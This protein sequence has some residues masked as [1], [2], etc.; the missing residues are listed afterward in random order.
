QDWID[1][2]PGDPR[3][4][5]LIVE[6]VKQKNLIK[7]LKQEDLKKL[8]KKQRR[9]LEERVWKFM[10]AFRRILMAHAMERPYETSDVA[11]IH[12]A[13]NT[14]LTTTLVKMDEFE[15]KKIHYLEPQFSES[16]RSVAELLVKYL[17]LF[18]L[19][20]K[21]V[22]FKPIAICCRDQCGSL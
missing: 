4:L 15:G 16:A 20:P 1:Q 11:A 5:R 19:T 2:P 3:H 22:H 18:H 8:S 21:L 13:L 10:P 7:N 14:P 12:E 9:S 6:T 17:N